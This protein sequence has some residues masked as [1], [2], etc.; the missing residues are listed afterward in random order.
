M[1]LVTVKE[2]ARVLRRSEQTIRSDIK[3]GRISALRV[4]PR[5]L[6]IDPEEALRAFPRIGEQ[7]E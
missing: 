4:G 2:L 5:G 6:R 3:R 1:E 7:L